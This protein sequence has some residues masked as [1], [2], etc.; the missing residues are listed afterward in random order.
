M[1][2][3]HIFAGE[4]ELDEYH[5]LVGQCVGTHAETKRFLH[6]MLHGMKAFAAKTAGKD[7]TEIAA[8]MEQARTADPDEMG[9]VGPLVDGIRK[10]LGMP[11]ISERLKAGQV[12]IDAVKAILDQV[13]AVN[14]RR[15]DI[16]HASAWMQNGKIVLQSGP[17]FGDGHREVSLEEMKALVTESRNVWTETGRCAAQIQRAL[18]FP[19]SSRISVSGTKAPEQ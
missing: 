11:V 17:L 7:D 19:G 6:Y 14:K 1:T 13:K 8:M 15:N 4:A 3:R 2:V 10:H 5:R 12:D 18:P 16:A 9:N